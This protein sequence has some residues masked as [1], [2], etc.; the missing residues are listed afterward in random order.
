MLGLRSSGMIHCNPLFSIVW[1]LPASWP[2]Q[3]SLVEAKV[4]LK[5]SPLPPPLAAVVGLKSHTSHTLIIR[6]AYCAYYMPTGQ[7]VCIAN[8]Y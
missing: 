5:I 7:W 3:R 2:V 4:D 6:H 1:I 8:K